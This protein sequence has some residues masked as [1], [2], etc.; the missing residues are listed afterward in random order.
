MFVP[1]FSLE[2][3]ELSLKALILTFILPFGPSNYSVE[4][5][6]YLIE[7]LFDQFDWRIRIEHNN[8]VQP[9]L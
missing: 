5:G 3:M 8:K 2:Y 7:Y 9:N 1:I 4:P 6:K